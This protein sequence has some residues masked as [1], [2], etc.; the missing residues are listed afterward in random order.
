MRINLTQDLSLK[1]IA[2]EAGS[3]SYHFGRIFAA[4][5][6]ETVFD[7]LRRV[8][9]VTALRML[10]EDLHV[11][12]TEVALSIGYETPSAFNKAFKMV[13]QISPSD[14][15]NLGKESQ[16]EVLYSLSKGPKPKEI[17][18]NL[19]QTPE[20]TQ[21]PTTHYIFMHK[22]GPFAEVAIPAW[23]ELFPLIEGKIEKTDITGFLGLS[24]LDKTRKDE[25]AMLYDAG[26]SVSK[27]PAKV[28]KGLGYKKIPGGKY[29]RFVLTG[30]YHQVWPAFSKVFQILTEK[31]IKLR[32][33]VCIENYLNDPNVTPEDQLITEILVPVE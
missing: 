28:P 30:P 26:I 12:V 31:K 29:A 23:T 16:E 3:S 6:G 21:W 9:M 8:R 19:T 7:F 22:E 10:Q 32:E 33:G 17:I 25:S 18:M 4:Y 2:T 20:I 11:S 13:V 24:C 14:F 5:T 15:R 1:K 27:E